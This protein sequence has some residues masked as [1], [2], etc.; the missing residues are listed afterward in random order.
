MSLPF[1]LSYG[2]LWLVVL[3]LTVVVLGLARALHR[4]GDENLT[5]STA[6]LKGE[7]APDFSVTDLSGRTIESADLE[8]RLSALLFV[9][10]DCSTCSVTL[11]EMNAIQAKTNGHV[12]V[13]CRSTGDRCA[14]MAETY[15]LNVPVVVDEDLEISRLF[16]VAAAPTAV[17][18]G[19]DGRIDSYGQPM[20]PEEFEQ[21]IA[22]RDGRGE[23]EGEREPLQA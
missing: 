12:I 11:A 19:A 21:S 6:G 8:G 3:Y 9:S 7:P 20:S 22:E 18:I 14:Q 17:L 10:P 5:I 23:A 13:F 1:W 16:E 15:G 2:A 4:L